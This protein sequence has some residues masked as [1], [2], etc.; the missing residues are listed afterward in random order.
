MIAVDELKR[1]IAEVTAAWQARHAPV[2]LR[3]KAF[4]DDAGLDLITTLEQIGVEFVD[5]GDGVRLCSTKGAERRRETKVAFARAVR[6]G[7]DHVWFVDISRTS[8]WERCGTA[9]SHAQ[10]R[11][12]V[13][14]ACGLAGVGGVDVTA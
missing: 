14:V 10:L 11:E 3:L 6:A 1:E 8:G 9:S 13:L 12:L 5:A 4:R 7:V 2:S